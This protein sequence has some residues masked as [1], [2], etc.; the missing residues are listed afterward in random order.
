MALYV[1]RCHGHHSLVSGVDARSAIGLYGSSKQCFLPGAEGDDAS[2]RVVGRYPDRDTVAGDHFYA[3]PPHAA[4]QLRQNFV[5]LV[6][7]HTVQ[8][9]AVDSHD[10]A[11]NINQIVLAQ[12]FSV[13]FNQRLCHIMAWLRKHN[14][15]SRFQQGRCQPSDRTA[16][17]RAAASAG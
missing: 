15:S 16:A 10:G 5:T 11:L 17:S 1:A 4:A 13:P 2:H 14:Y 7:L 6:T 9:T 12:L 8:P 3:K